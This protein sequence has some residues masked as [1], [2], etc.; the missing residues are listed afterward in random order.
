MSRPDET[1]SAVR[2]S[3][4]AWCGQL[5]VAEPLAFGVAFAATGHPAAPGATQLRDVR[6]ADVSGE[7][8]FA[9]AE[10]HF[11]QAGAACDRW[12]PASGQP[13]EPV[14]ALLTPRGWRRVERCAF[15]LQAAAGTARSETSTPDDMRILPARA[16]RKAYAATFAEEPAAARDAALDRLNDANLDAFVAVAGGR[17]VG[18]AAYLEVGDI[19]RL[20]DVRVLADDRRRGVG[21][22]LAAQFVRLAGRL[23]PR[24][25]VA[26][27]DADDAAA[28]AYLSAC[29]FV[30]D[31]RL[32]EFR[33]NRN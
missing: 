30:E 23:L 4:E 9:Q 3:D 19:A 2:R 5:A 10:A 18:R 7:A 22:R 8:A 31:G 6:L 1:L 33:R 16:M 29:G 27:C 25:A 11:A 32:I 15:A 26:A 14:A 17:A 12:V 13:V 24:A 28:R 21:R 20:I